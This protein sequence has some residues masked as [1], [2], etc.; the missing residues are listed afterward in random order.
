[1]RVAGV[2]VVLGLGMALGCASSQPEPVPALWV[3][4][5]RGVPSYT[6]LAKALEPCVME[7]RKLAAHFYRSPDPA[8]A[9]IE[10]GVMRCMERGGWVRIQ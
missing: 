7:G 9:W 4:E 5:E 2:V 8:E 10:Y 6:E 1:M 3:H